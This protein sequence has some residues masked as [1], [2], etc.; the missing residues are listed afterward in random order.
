MRIV[1]IIRF[2]HCEYKTIAGGGAQRNFLGVYMY[3][4][5]ADLDLLFDDAPTLHCLIFGQQEVKTSPFG[6]IIFV[7]ETDLVKLVHAFTCTCV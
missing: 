5:C 7:L 4:S 2:S 1:L 3:I 6:M